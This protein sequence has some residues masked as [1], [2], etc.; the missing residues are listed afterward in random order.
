M[1]VYVR[2]LVVLAFVSGCS[3]AS[4]TI[5]KVSV[6][7]PDESELA[8]VNYYP[9]QWEMD[10]CLYSGKQAE[11]VDIQVRGGKIVLQRWQKKVD[12]T[13]LFTAVIE[14]GHQTEISFQSKDLVNENPVVNKTQWTWMDQ[15]IVGS[16]LFLPGQGDER[17]NWS[18]VATGQFYIKKGEPHKM[19]WARWGSSHSDRHGQQTWQSECVY[20]RVSK[21]VLPEPRKGE[22]VKLPEIAE[23]I[24]SPKSEAKVWKD[25]SEEDMGSLAADVHQ[26]QMDLMSRG[27]QRADQSAGQ[28]HDRFESYSVPQPRRSVEMELFKTR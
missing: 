8:Q 5:E 11:R 20:N 1:A 10:R 13:P 6:Q 17:G 14:P 24:Y 16:M 15:R 19:R 26:R 25:S 2:L 4:K 18:A 23:S 3:T 21:L 22:E 7:S 27:E 9:G 12:Q 28:L